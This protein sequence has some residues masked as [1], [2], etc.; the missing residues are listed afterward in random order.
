MNPPPEALFREMIAAG[1][2][3]LSALKLGEKLASS[4]DRDPANG[5]LAEEWL[6]SEKT[7]EDAAI[8][9]TQTI[10]RYHESLPAAFAPSRRHRVGDSERKTPKTP[11]NEPG[12]R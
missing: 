2:R 8:A 4:L 6:Q 1:E 3:L 12:G 10:A 7:L 9:Y 5:T 11:K